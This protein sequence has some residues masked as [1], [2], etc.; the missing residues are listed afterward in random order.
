MKTKHV[1]FALLA[2]CMAAA[3]AHSCADPKN[4]AVI[5]PVVTPPI[6]TLPVVTP[7]DDPLAIPLLGKWEWAKEWEEWNW[8]EP[9]SSIV[10][11][12]FGCM[13][14]LPNG[15][16]RWYDY[17]ASDTTSYL[18]G[19]YKVN[20]S[21]MAI[22]EIPLGEALLYLHFLISQTLF[23]D[24]D[25]FPTTM[26]VGQNEKCVFYLIPEDMLVLDLNTI[27]EGSHA[28]RDLPYAPV[29]FIYKRKK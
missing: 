2:I 10:S 28:I 17:A 15:V 6:D 23:L 14:Y 22:P 29:R 21:F 1:F 26:F 16:V 4:D 18:E 11:S 3:G 5:P 20:K 27:I 9:S 12:S 24:D 19:K 25:V 13:E 7:P 8:I